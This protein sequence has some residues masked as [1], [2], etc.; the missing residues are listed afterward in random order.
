M[1]RK[2]G[3]KSVEPKL[4]ACYQCGDIRMVHKGKELDFCRGCLA[5][6]HMYRMMTVEELAKRIERNERDGYHA[7]AIKTA[8]I[9]DAL[10]KTEAQ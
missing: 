10:L 2:A 4:R 7:V 6:G 9:R 3:K 1:Y 8:L 5:Q